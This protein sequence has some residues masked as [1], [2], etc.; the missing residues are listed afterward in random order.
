MLKIGKKKPQPQRVHKKA[1]DQ[2][3]VG[4]PV[5]GIGP[6]LECGQITQLLSTGENDFSLSHQ[7]S[8]TNSGRIWEEL[9]EI[10]EYDQNILYGNFLSKNKY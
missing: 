2:F 1:W 8:I 5:L 9:V 7:L 3:C 6:A 4:Q 10:K